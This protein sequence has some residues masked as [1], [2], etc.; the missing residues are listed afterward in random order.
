MITASDRNGSS[1]TGRTFL[2]FGS[3][4]ATGLSYQGLLIGMFNGDAVVPV[5]RGGYDAIIPRLF[6]RAWAKR[7]SYYWAVLIRKC[8]D[9]NR[10]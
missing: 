1:D 2:Y 8:A 9:G 7:R 5:H 6:E 10:G 4:T 3:L